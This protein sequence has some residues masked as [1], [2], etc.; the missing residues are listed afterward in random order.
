MEINP[1]H[2]MN[3]SFDSVED[4]SEESFTPTI[5]KPFLEEV[6]YI[7][8]PLS[9]GVNDL[10]IHASL[11]MQDSESTKNAFHISEKNTNPLN[12]GLE[13]VW[14]DLPKKEENTLDESE[15]E[16]EKMAID[17]ENS[18]NLVHKDAE[19]LP[20]AS[21]EETFE[22]LK[23]ETHTEPIIIE[24]SPE[25]EKIGLAENTEW[26]A[27][28]EDVS[29]DD[30]ASEVDWMETSVENGEENIVSVV[31]EAEISNQAEEIFYPEKI[32]DDEINNKNAH[33]NTQD[34]AQ[35]TLYKGKYKIQIAV[36]KEKEDMFVNSPQKNENQEDTN[37]IDKI[38]KQ[39]LL[40]EPK[41]QMQKN[42]IE[43]PST[44]AFE[45]LENE[46]DTEIIT[47]T[48]AKIYLVQGNKKGAIE[49]YQKLCLLFPEKNTYFADQ[50]EKIRNNE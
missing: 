35:R 22:E 39:F 18:E 13:T 34:G 41:M 19:I 8:S 21:K 4:I 11:I 36:P 26:V 44:P 47:E 37:S 24:A 7:H 23:E 48:M 17:T 46:E 14:I 45:P 28:L 40:T 31:S 32:E 25:M 33:T 9:K 5:N 49:I 10:S 27:I 42:R 20:L 29:L 3:F 2:N 50:I 15:I 43:K 30:A 12:V 38:I 16:A 1:S 6:M